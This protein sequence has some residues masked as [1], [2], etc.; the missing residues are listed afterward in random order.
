MQEEACSVIF[1]EVFYISRGKFR[2]SLNPSQQVNVKL[3]DIDGMN[4]CVAIKQNTGG[5]QGWKNP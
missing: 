3:W 5:V 4:Y 1:T 2:S